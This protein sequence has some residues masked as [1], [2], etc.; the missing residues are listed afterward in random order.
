MLNMTRRGR[1]A[2]TRACM[3][4]AIITAAENASNAAAPMPPRGVLLSVHPPA[5]PPPGSSSS[6]PS[7]A[8]RWWQ[9]QTNCSQLQSW[10]RGC[11]RPWSPRLNAAPAPRFL[12]PRLEGPGTIQARHPL[13]SW[14]TPQR[15][16]ARA[17]SPSQTCRIARCSRSAARRT[18]SACV[19][20]VTTATCR[21][22]RATTS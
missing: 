16:R 19:T 7:L 6:V 21:A 22:P 4:A 1:R 17:Y 8:E 9:P 3:G 12:A 5:Q 14:Q 13:F 11:S 15:A 20:A 10:F 18:S 2:H